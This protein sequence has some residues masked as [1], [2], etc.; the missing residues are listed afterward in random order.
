QCH[1]AGAQRGCRGE[2]FDDAHRDT[3]RWNRFTLQARFAPEGR[4][5][6]GRRRRGTGEARR[7]GFRAGAESHAL[8]SPLGARRVPGKRGQSRNLKV[9]SLILGQELAKPHSFTVAQHTAHRLDKQNRLL[10]EVKRV[11]RL[12]ELTYLVVTIENRDPSKVW[13]LDRPEI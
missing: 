10:A 6:S 4:R 9:A 5:H 12:F 8:S 3:Q 2:E 1:S 13:V 7:T 11:Y